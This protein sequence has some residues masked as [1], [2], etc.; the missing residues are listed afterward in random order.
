MRDD[1]LPAIVESVPRVVL[2]GEL[3]AAYE[4]FRAAA[5]DIEGKAT[6]YRLSQERYQAALG[7]L[8]R[9]AGKVE[10]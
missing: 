9:L 4:D 6:A 10:S 7:R 2:E 5:A 3:A 1:T 8:S